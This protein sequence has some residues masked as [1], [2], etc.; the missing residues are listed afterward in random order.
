MQKALHHLISFS[1][2]QG[3]ESGQHPGL[4]QGT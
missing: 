4:P 2:N 3:D 1:E